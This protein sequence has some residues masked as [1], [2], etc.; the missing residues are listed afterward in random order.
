MTTITTIAQRI[1][2]ENNFITMD[3]S[4]TT[5]TSIATQVLNQNNYTTSQ[6]SAINVEK[7]MNLAIEY[8]NLI[9]DTD[10]AQIASPDG[11]KSLVGTKAENYCIQLVTAMMIR[12]YIDRGPSVNMATLNV[13]TTINEPQYATFKSQIDDAIK[14]LRSRIKILDAEYHVKNAV[15]YINAMA[16]TTITFVPSDGAQSLTATD[17]EIIAVKMV[18]SE[19]LKNYVEKGM[20]GFSVSE[21]TNKMINRLCG[22]SFER[23]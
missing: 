2:D 5:I 22:V 6:C 18:A 8:I 10:I 19:L 9:G 16:G 7:I 21:A 12:A 15:D 20:A 11:T 3:S 17:N 4:D 13:A 14:K 1:L 23:T